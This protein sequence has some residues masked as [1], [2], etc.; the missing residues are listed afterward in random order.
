MTRNANYPPN[1]TRYS[2]ETYVSKVLKKDPN[3]LRE[4][5]EDVE[6]EYS[7]PRG[8]DRLFKGFYKNRGPYAS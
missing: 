4:S 5:Q 3:W 2:S 8:G 1:L 6:F 7:K